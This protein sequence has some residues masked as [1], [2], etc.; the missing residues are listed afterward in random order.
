M[1]EHRIGSE[2]EFEAARDELL[3][4]EKNHTRRA[5]ELA[6]KRRAPLGAD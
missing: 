1:T 4:E 3:A 2:Q 6:E 5:D